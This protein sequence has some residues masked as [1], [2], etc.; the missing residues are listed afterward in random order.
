PEA[1]PYPHHVPKQPDGVSLRFA[2][3]NDV[4]HERFPRHGQAYYQ[5]RNRRVRRALAEL[6]E[7]DEAGNRPPERYFDLLDDLAVGL[8]F[9]GEHDEAIRV[10]R[11][12]L[13]R[14]EAIGHSGRALYSTYANLGTFLILGPFREVRPGNEDDKRV[15]R[16]G[17]ALIRKSIQVN[18]D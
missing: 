11:D 15:L 4:L 12:K 13:A 6:K 2:M 9:A 1:L 7:R 17:L 16:E 14:Q 18:P 8:E 3:V 5:D 10:I